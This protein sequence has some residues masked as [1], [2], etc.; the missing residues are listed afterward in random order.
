MTPADLPARLSAIRP[1]A[2]TD[3][4]SEPHRSVR[5]LHFQQSPGTS[6]RVVGVPPSVDI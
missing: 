2:L 1:F 5:C 6:T 4:R 3:C